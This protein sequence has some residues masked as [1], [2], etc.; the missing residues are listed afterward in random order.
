MPEHVADLC[1]RLSKTWSFADFPRN[2]GC[3][4]PVVLAGAE[5]P[6]ESMATRHLNIGKGKWTHMLLEKNVS[7]VLSH[8]SWDV[9]GVMS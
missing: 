7:G 8:Y 2:S 6:R 5:C 1:F 4:V 9:H 3:L